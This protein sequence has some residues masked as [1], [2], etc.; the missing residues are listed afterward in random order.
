MLRR[1]SATVAVV[2]TIA[3]VLTLV[4][5][6]SATTRTGPVKQIP[7]KQIPVATVVGAP[8]VNAPIAQGSY[9]SYPNRTKREKVVIRKRVL[10][11]IKSTWGGP[12]DAYGAA[13]AGNG[14]I[15]IAT[16]TLKD[17][18]IA[19][20]LYQ[21]HRRGV[22]VQV[23]AAAGPNRKSRPW[24]WLRGKLRG[25]LYRTGHPETLERWSFA[26]K[27]RGSC[28]GNGGTA[29][30][31]Y[32][33][34]TNVGAS[35]VPTVTVQ[36]SMNLTRK[37]FTGQW[38]QA[39]VTWDGGVHGS[40]STVFRETRLDRPVASPY[41]RYTSGGIQ[42]IFFPR[43]G[44]TAPYDP[45][46]QALSQVRCL[47]A[48]SGGDASRRTRIR[49]IQ[50][51]I[52]GTRGTWIAKRLREL[53]NSGCNV[54]IIYSVSSRPVLSILRSKSGRGAVPMRQSV[55]RNRSGDI[56]KYNHSKWLTITGSV[57]ASTGAWIVLPGSANWSNLAL[58]SDEQM[59]QIYSYAYT[60]AYLATFTKTW[61]QRTS[62]VPKFGRT[63][64]GARL[65]PEE[66]QFGKGV[67]RYLPED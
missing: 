19:R 45:I 17:W 50:Y 20:A 26:R 10:N 48:T 15:R 6:A 62:R 32:F 59:Q 37:A 4:G 8:P 42:S 55:I 58:T 43:P 52:Y 7:V 27:C 34:F 25:A 39:T 53:W 2:A 28:R 63:A 23:V 38:N 36:T 13:V 47:G 31:K 29:H 66:P 3:F 51:A 12:R 67:Y 64:S 57:G 46:M 9:F 40:F 21:A 18:A 33:L 54:R 24:R 35:H 22:S 30:S 41:R 60:R 11:T 44:A 56:V 49:I 61:R 65:V 5:D 1:R 16:W 14:T